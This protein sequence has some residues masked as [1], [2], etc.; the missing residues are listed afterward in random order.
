[1]RGQM[2]MWANIASR[3]SFDEGGTPSLEE[4]E[5]R[6]LDVGGFQRIQAAAL[7]LVGSLMG[8]LGFVFAAFLGFYYAMKQDKHQ[9]FLDEPFEHSYFS[10]TVSEMVYNPKLAQG[11]VFFGFVLISSLSM[12]MSWY[13]WRLRNVWIGDDLK[14]FGGWCGQDRAGRPRGI[15]VL[16]LRQFMPPIGMLLVATIPA[17]PGAN[18]EFT[19]QVSCIIHTIGAVMSIGG[20][21]V[22]ELYTLLWARQVVFDTSIRG[23][24]HRVPEKLARGILISMCLFC[25]VAFQICGVLQN[26][27][28]QL[29]ICCNDVWE[30][31]TEENIAMLK[32]RGH[33]GQALID[34]IANEKGEKMLLSTA[35]GAF[36]VIKL[37]EYWF[38][39]GSGLFMLASHL[40]I[41][42]YCP[43]RYIDL[44]EDLVD[45]T[46]EDGHYN[47]M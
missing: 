27:G 16:M 33:I 36:M 47:R 39:V 38:E 26:R 12:M 21:A 6:L 32:A 35:S 31:P 17:P 5:W 28:D 1:M 34:Q 18:R 15:T 37:C 45:A 11:K 2:E 41:W 44:P 7:L 43:E 4:H 22:I 25:I 29:G 23:R 24:R 9:N 20:Y 40:T 3:Q 8:F 10:A 42:Y 19:D 46:G 14:L 13:P 30:V